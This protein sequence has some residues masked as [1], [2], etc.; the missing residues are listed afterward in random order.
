MGDFLIVWPYYLVPFGKSFWFSWPILGVMGENCFVI[1]S[2][3]WFAN[4]C[5]DFGSFLALLFCTFRGFFF[6]SWLLEGKSKYLVC[7]LTVFGLSRIF[8]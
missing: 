3:A 8:L 5:V 1:G 7:S 6:R 4:F 2:Y